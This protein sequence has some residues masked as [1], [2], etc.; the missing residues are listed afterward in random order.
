MRIPV[1]RGM[2]KR[3]LL[4]NFR[5]DPE[6]VQRILPEPF[7][8]KLHA[9]HA[10]VGVCLIRLE[11]IRP[12]GLPG[13]IGLSSENAAHR[14]AV[15]WQDAQGLQK[16]GVFIPRRDTN[17]LLNRLAGG[18]VFPGE[19]HAARFSV[20][21][22][23]GHIDFAMESVDGTTGVRVSGE[24]GDSFPSSS[25]FASLEQAS[26]FF[27][28]GSLGYSITRDGNRMDGLRLRTLDWRVYALAISSIYSSF[29]DDQKR[30]PKGSIEFD[31]ALIMRNLP[32]EWHQGEDLYSLP[33]QPPG[34]LP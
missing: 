7:R 20:A 22:K 33:P 15:Q 19:H 13:I 1:I 32:H 31:H 26:A 29:F 14:I 21:E 4:V 8:P 3:R 27:E 28:G 12:A 11:Q 30:F 23:G 25:C 16:E 24:E 17:A 10:V 2:I 18:R 9:G 5:A 34:N 6:T